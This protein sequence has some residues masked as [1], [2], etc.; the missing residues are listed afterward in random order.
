M[1]LLVYCGSKSGTDGRYTEAALQLAEALVARDI[2]LVFGGGAVG[3]MG[4][5]AKAMLSHGGRVI[6]IIPTFLRTEEVALET[7]TE[8]IEVPSMHA[9]KL[10]MMEH[11]H[12]I[13]AI[14]GGFGTMDELFEAVT[15]RQIGLH[16]KPIGLWNVAGYYDHLSSMV[17][18]MLDDG[19]MGATT[20]AMLRIDDALLPMLDYLEANAS[21]VA[22]DPLLPRWT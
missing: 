2:G 6:G 12:A 10:L 14:P 7:C 3:L 15:W 5:V 21:D 13:L 1:N 4:D 19:F 17:D 22:P 8:L 16:N 11:S 20:H 9:R 18:R